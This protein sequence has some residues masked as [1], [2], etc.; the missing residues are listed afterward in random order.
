VALD[1]LSLGLVMRE[2]LK[3]MLPPGAREYR[4]PPMFVLPKPW[5]S[6]IHLKSADPAA[7]AEKFQGAGLLAAWLDE[8]PIGENGRQIFHE[9]NARRTPGIPL[10]IFMT[11][12]PLQGYSWSYRELWN[13]ETRCFPDVETFVVTQLD[14]AISHG[15]FWTDKELK[16]F[17]AGYTEAEWEARVMGTYGILAGS[18]Y[19]SKKLI[20]EQKPKCETPKRYDIS[21]SAISGPQLKENPSGSLRIYRPPLKDRK[22]IMG[23]DS[24]SGVGRDY[25]VASVWDRK[26]LALVAE[27]RDNRVYA[28]KFGQDTVLPLAQHYSNALIVP[29]SNSD[30]G[31]TIINEL[32]NRYHNIYRWRKWNAVKRVYSMEFGWRTL[33]T[34][35]MAI[36]D[37]ISKA[38][39]E[40]Q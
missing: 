11:F 30:H 22:Y 4:Q 34:N 2:K 24:A 12:T 32:R 16:D 13:P 35:R 1:H 38:L 31:G 33:G 19:F 25:S 7:G 29:E 28:H 3:A 5:E 21:H 9:I 40:G 17:Q 6:E 39:R 36:Y 23:V 14:A 10:H 20:E 27:W 37:A 15:G 26:D 18:C 8:E